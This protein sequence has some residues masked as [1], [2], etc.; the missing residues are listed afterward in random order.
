MYI[1]I[2]NIETGIKNVLNINFSEYKSFNAQGNRVIFTDKND[3][4]TSMV[5]ESEEEALLASERM[6]YTLGLKS[7]FNILLD[8]TE[9]GSLYHG[10]VEAK[11]LTLQE[12]AE[13]FKIDPR[14]LRITDY[15]HLQEKNTEEDNNE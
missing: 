1:K 5:F 4:K 7:P 8:L 2:K 10:K 13:K 15:P 14:E 3:Q 11:E 9:D 6:F 12:I